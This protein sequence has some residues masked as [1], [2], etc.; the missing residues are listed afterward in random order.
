MALHSANAGHWS[1][2]LVTRHATWSSEF[3][4]LL[5]LDPEKTPP[6]EFAFLNMLHPQDRPAVIEA[7][8][9]LFAG[10]S[11]Q[12]RGEFRFVRPSGDMRWLSMTGRLIRGRYSQ[13]LHVTGVAVDITAHKRSES[14]LMRTRAN[15]E[16]RV[17]ART[18]A[19]QAANRNLEQ[20]IDS[21]RKL[22]RQLLEV[23]E[24]EQQRI[25]QDLHDGLGQ[26]IT[27]II[28]HTH[29]LQKHLAEQGAKEAGSAA[30]IVA[31]LDQAKTQARQISRGLQPVEPSSGGLMAGLAN[32]AATTSDLYHI[33]CHFDCPDPVLVEDYTK[34]THLFRIAQE[35]VANAFRHGGARVV[36]IHLRRHTD[37]GSVELTIADDGGGL[38][39]EKRRRGGLGLQFMRYRAEAMGGTFAAASRPGGGTLIS[40]RVPRSPYSSSHAAPAPA[41]LPAGKLCW[42]ARPEKPRKRRAKTPS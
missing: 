5:G 19:L 34:A 12:M 24:R 23:S 18:A 27:G 15:L 36:E 21:R 13:P 17:K 30:K 31:L 1:I 4:Q 9:Q 16:K 40:C 32:F 22:E 7:L 38:P 10:E 20:Q 28:F 37:D 8:D 25:G 6:D 11:D 2:D 33:Q 26:Q 29:L 14:L 39:E 41:P 42:P 3:F 35:A